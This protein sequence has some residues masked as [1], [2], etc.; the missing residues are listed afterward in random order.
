MSKF[1][2]Q[3]KSSASK[4]PATRTGHRDITASVQSWKGSI[5]TSMYYNCEEELCIEV[6]H[7]E[8]SSMQ[9]THLFS[10][11]IEEYIRALKEA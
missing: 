5:I 9:G 11:T 2:G 10:G 4:T 8:G 3:V 1:Y 6:S 7:A